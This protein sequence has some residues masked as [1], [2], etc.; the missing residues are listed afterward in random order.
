VPDIPEEAGAVDVPTAAID[1]LART[2]YDYEDTDDDEITW[3]EYRPDAKD[4]L[5]ILA[6]ILTAQVRREYEDLLGSIWLYIG[7]RYVT[8]QLT[9]PQREMFADAVEAWSRRM[10]NDDPDELSGVE[11]WWRPETLARQIGESRD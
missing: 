6:P 10:N 11:R 9:T 5:D 1:A 2:L 8:K 7:W 4:M 3:E